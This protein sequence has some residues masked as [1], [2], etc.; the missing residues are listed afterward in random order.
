MTELFHLEQEPLDLLH[1]LV[2]HGEEVGEDVLGDAD[3]GGEARC[4]LVFPG[5]EHL[6]QEDGVCHAHGIVGG[7]VVD[8]QRIAGHLVHHLA[9]AQELAQG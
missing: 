1:G 8:G 6:L 5:G 9:A 7:A 2:E 4:V 3:L